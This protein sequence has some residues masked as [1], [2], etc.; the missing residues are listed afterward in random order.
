M[1][2]PQ[3][4]NIGESMVISSNPE[5][6]TD[7]PVTPNS[8]VSWSTDNPCVT[9]T[10]QGALT[11]ECE[12]L[13]VSEGTANITM[14]AINAASATITAPYQAIVSPGLFTQFN[15]TNTPPS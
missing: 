8:S 14:S 6:A 9:L 7:G 13:A 2:T 5:N 11:E 15:P 3:P 10:P 12:V 4:M 1:P